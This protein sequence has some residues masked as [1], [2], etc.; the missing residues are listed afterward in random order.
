MYPTRPDEPAY[1]FLPDVEAPAAN[2]HG[3]PIQLVEEGHPLAGKSLNINGDSH[4][5]SNPNRYKQHGFY[6]NADNCIAC[7]ACEAAC[8]SVRWGISKAAAIRPANA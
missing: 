1:A 5:G 7:H 8:R 4:I 3:K 6:F 2:C